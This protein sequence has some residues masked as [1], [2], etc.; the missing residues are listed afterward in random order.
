MPT[1]TTLAPTTTTTT[2]QPTWGACRNYTCW[3]EL[4]PGDDITV[5]RTLVQVRGL[6]RTGGDSRVWADFGAGHFASWLRHSC[7]S[8]PVGHS[9][10]GDG[11]GVFGACWA[12]S[13]VVEDTGYWLGNSSEA[14]FLHW[15]WGRPTNPNYQGWRLHLYNAETGDNDASA[16]MTQGTQYA[17]YPHLHGGQ[18]DVQIFV[19]ATMTLV[20]TLSVAV[21][22]ARSY[23]YA[24]VVN[25]GNPGTDDDQIS[26]DVGCWSFGEDITT[27]TQTPE[28]PI[29]TAAPTTTTTTLPP[30]GEFHE[31]DVY[32][33][34]V[35]CPGLEIR[36]LKCSYVGP[37]SADLSYAGRHDT[38]GGPCGCSLGAT[39][40]VQDSSTGEVVFR[41]HVEDEVPGG[42]AREGVDYVAHGLRSRLENEPVNINGR[43]FYCWN[44]RGFRCGHKSGE[45]SPGRD[46]GFWTVG[47]IILDILEHAKGIPAEGSD[48]AGHH[49]SAGCVTDTYLSDDDLAGYDAAAILAID[50]P[51]GEFSVSNTPL[52]AAIE[53][54]LAWAGQFYGWY[55]DT[56]GV[57]RVVDLKNRPPISI[58]AGE[59]GQWQDAGGRNY[60]LLDNDLTYS[61][62]GVYSRV[63]VQ[64]ADRTVEVKPANIETSGNAALNDGGELELVDSPWGDWPCAYRNLDQ[65]YRRWTWK[66]VGWN[67]S[68]RYGG[69]EC[70]VP[71]NQFGI[72]WGPRVYKGT[73]AG[74]KEFFTGPAGYQWRVNQRTGIVMFYY[75][76]EGELE[77]EEKLWGWY[78]ASVPFTVE[79]GPA[80]N[81]Y[82]CF[83]RDRTFKVHD[84]AFKAPSGYP[85]AGNDEAAMQILA[86][87]LLQ[88]RKNV[89]VQGRLQID[90]LDPTT[91]H[92]LYRF[93]VTRLESA[94]TST[95]AACWPPPVNWSTLKASCVEVTYDFEARTTELTVANTFY[96][97]EGYSELKNKL[98]QGLLAGREY[99]LSEN[100]VS[101]QVQAG[102]FDP[103]EQEQ[104]YGTTTGYPPTTTTTTTTLAPPTTTTTAYALGCDV[105]DTFNRG[106]SD[107]MGANWTE[108]GTN[109]E[110]A[111]HRAEVQWAGVTGVY[112]SGRAV[113]VN[114]VG[115]ND[116]Q[117]SVTLGNALSGG[118][119]TRRYF[120][121]VSVRHTAN[122]C[123]GNYYRGYIKSDW[124]G[125]S[126]QRRVQKI[127]GGTFTLAED[128]GNSGVGEWNLKVDGSDL[129]WWRTDLGIGTALTANDSDIASG[130]YGGFQ[131]MYYAET[132]GGISGALWADNFCM[133]TV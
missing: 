93:N 3:S 24:F 82:E 103:D 87:R 53:E 130:Q 33:N 49:S 18:L 51:I 36:Q 29:T 101:C 52:A 43:A 23:R 129:W 69:D 65:P 110:I 107:D 118:S 111:N 71:D 55:V 125:G 127:M 41:G 32:V 37:W 25:S 38:Y 106:D 78:W 109:M 64:G 76:A 77:G 115:S 19:A 58:E 92:L 108:C 114:A 123:T 21:D 14:L 96:M 44:T 74:A 119:N 45:D 57:L 67:G 35:L 89:R 80:G 10:V 124:G 116:H 86:D 54:L 131:L 59:L 132:N 4:D 94:T 11:I 126:D 79:A 16:I 15:E 90:E 50:T 34:G 73:E 133:N 105:E 62:D 104:Q 99:A 47:E 113:N 1:T 128:T 83:G 7:L 46:G 27:T 88:Q 81:A 5:F 17:F 66:G 56:G 61:L 84:P 13:N 12:V 63:L 97:L 42:V 112:R 85:Q 22:P 100:I 40:R 28:I 72:Y 121:Y 102:S 20:D 26:F 91:N 39:V 31:F 95:S 48:I 117:T 30:V 60:T 68:C 9:I 2:C 8:T 98:E 6:S 122:D 70:G 75:D 120:D